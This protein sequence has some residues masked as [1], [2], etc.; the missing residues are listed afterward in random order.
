[1]TADTSPRWLL[2]VHDE[3]A[4]EVV[5]LKNG[6]GCE[7][8]DARNVLLA[9]AKETDPRRPANPHLNV[10]SIEYDAPGWYR[11]KTWRYNMRI[12][13]RLLVRRGRKIIELHS[14]D[15]LEADID[16]FAIQVTRVAY[17]SCVYG[18]PLKVRRRKIH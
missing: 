2:T 14:S 17:R 16:E 15:S 1:M 9:L 8:M 18:W 10:C 7:Y 4:A 6:S 11:V 12:V 5:S 3:A 13:F